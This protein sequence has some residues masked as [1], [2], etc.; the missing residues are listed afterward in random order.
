[1]SNAQKNDLPFENEGTAEANEQNSLN[2]QVSGESQ[3]LP[4]EVGETLP[5]EKKV[6]LDLDGADFLNDDQE[7][8]A[9]EEE[10]ET[11]EENSSEGAAEEKPKSKKKLFIIVGAVVLLLVV[12]VLGWWFFLRETEPPVPP[13]EPII[14]E[15][16]PQTPVEP[17]PSDDF[18]VSFDPFWV[19]LPDEKGGEVFLVCKFAIV[20]KSKQ[21]SLEAQNK[22]VL[23]RDAV[24]YY[25]VNKPYH[26]LIDADNVETIKKDLM[27]VFSGYLVSGKIDD[28][29]FESYLGK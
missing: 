18:I 20:S 3:N 6:E 16:K 28:M 11:A 2:I 15:V 14:I 27:S 21:L 29:L 4:A 23:L 24:Y 7:E 22:I 13:I 12:G 1:M 9:T 25:L 19:P 26:F 8:E 5:A 17:A 10:E